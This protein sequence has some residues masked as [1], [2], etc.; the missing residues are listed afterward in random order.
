MPCCTW[1]IALIS[2]V[3]K[4]P[5][6]RCAKTD[7]MAKALVLLLLVECLVDDVQWVASD[8]WAVAFK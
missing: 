3:V 4:M 8:Q 2:L 1:F 7:L 5:V 6:S